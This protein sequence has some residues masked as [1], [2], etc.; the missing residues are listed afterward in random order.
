MRITI[1]IAGLGG[2]GAERV[3]VNLANAWVERGYEPTILTISQNSR[4][5]AYA[6]DARVALSDIGWPRWS[7]SYELNAAVVAPIM[8]GLQAARCPELIPDIKMLALLRY[9]I[10][11]TQPD[12][13]VS[14]IDQTNVRVL[15]AMHEARAPVIVC[16]VTDARRV[17]L[18]AWQ[19]ARE[20]LYHRASTVV[21]PDE[22]IASWFTA[23]GYHARA[24]PNPLVA[25]A[26]PLLKPVAPIRTNSTSRQRV[27][28]LSRLSA[29]KRPEWL[30]RAFA[31]VAQ[32]HPTWDLDLY[33]LGPQK[34][35]LEHLA[36]K[37][38]PGRV[39]FH[40]FTDDP[41]KALANADIFVSASWIEGFGN[42]IW[43]AL[44]SGVP[45][46]AMDAGPSVNKLV[47]HGIDG[48]IVKSNS[49]AALAAALERLMTNETERKRLASRAPEVINRF[50]LE[51]ALTQ[52]DDLLSLSHTR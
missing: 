8:R 21:A 5:P 3:C 24:I 23:R 42:A 51:A 35:T 32:K 29:E 49:V 34:N 30:L 16:E 13:V 20:A 1:V 11:T 2:G 31:I 44:A 43:E 36:E 41:Y 48:L 25:P 7:R 50:S 15:A 37:L 9:A 40:G 28:S 12:V 19:H 10:L 27:I 46:I 22:A 38:A 18:R 39:T 47:R 17:S 33:G 4:P 52:W 14:M 6:I 26:T 45:V